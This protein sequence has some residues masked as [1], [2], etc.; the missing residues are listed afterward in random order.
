MADVQLL[1]FGYRRD[2]SDVSN[3]ETVTGVHRQT[4]I[5][6]TPCRVAQRFNSCVRLR[7]VRIASGVELDRRNAELFRL[8]YCRTRRVDKEAHTDSG[9]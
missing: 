9:S 5:R 6:A 1:D 7:S 3:G 8:L 2:A 4:E